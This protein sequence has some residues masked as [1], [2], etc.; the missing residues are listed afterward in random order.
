MNPWNLAVAGL[1]A[2]F[3]LVS[4]IVAGL[5]LGAEA[6]VFWRCLLAAL[7]LPLIVLALGRARSLLPARR[8]LP[9]LGLGLL[10][11]A[12]W[13][14]FFAT[15]KRASVAVAI[16]LVYTAPIFLAIL[17]PLLLPERRSRVG[18]AALAVS[19]PGL[20]LISLAGDEGSA[21]DP[22]AL[23]LGLGAALGYALLIIGAKAV[24]RDT[25]PFALAFWQYVIVTIAVSPFLLA[26][27][28]V[29]PSPSEWPYVLVLGALLTAVTGVLYVR[30]LR[31]V[32]AQAAGLIAYLEPVSASLLAWAIL[33]ESLGWEVVVGGTAV[34]LGGGLVVVRE[35]AEPVSPEAPAV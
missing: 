10:L 5:D 26:G 9:I 17:A 27:G 30:S 35:P 14:L 16:L 22:V 34:I 18:L 20:A 7:T 3:G 33:G 1:A 31:H 32:T 13:L 23:G 21:A 4:V 28:Q 19:A 29:V 15:V 8:R 6:L 12:H 24:V 11:A 2:S 25:S